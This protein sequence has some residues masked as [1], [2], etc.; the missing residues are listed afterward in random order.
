MST[1]FL[2]TSDRATARWGSRDT[3]KRSKFSG[4]ACSGPCPG[5]G[6]SVT[7]PER[8]GAAAMMEPEP[9][10]AGP[11]EEAGGQEAQHEDAAP[12]KTSSPAAAPEQPAPAVADPAPPPAPLDP[13][14]PPDTPRWAES[15]ALTEIQPPAPAPVEA[16]PAA[17]GAPPAAAPP[18][19]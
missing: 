8:Q 10:P 16:A 1:S 7:H 19:E 5:T 18:E 9:V 4:E 17:P 2:R 11:E 3:V 12:A 6:P 15:A 14:P 13:P